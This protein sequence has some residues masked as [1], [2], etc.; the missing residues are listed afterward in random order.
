ML[1]DNEA[2]YS[3]LL[4]GKLGCCY[5]ITKSQEYEKY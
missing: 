5:L 3:E 4:A 2:N 1:L